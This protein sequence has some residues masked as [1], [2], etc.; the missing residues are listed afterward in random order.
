[1]QNVVVHVTGNSY[2]LGTIGFG[3]QERVK[4]RPSSESHVEISFLNA[5][6]QQ[7]RLVAACY[8][9]SRHYH[10]TIAIDVSGDKLVRFQDSVSIGMY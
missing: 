5:S 9:E 8:F 7:R 6:G 4:V 1:M 2:E 10:G 3:E